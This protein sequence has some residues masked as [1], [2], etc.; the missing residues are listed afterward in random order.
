M[1]GILPLG[2][3]LGTTEPATP[4]AHDG[5]APAALTGDN[6]T[7]V[8][9]GSHSSSSADENS[10]PEENAKPE[11]NSKPFNKAL[12]IPIHNELN[13][14]ASSSMDNVAELGGAE[15]HHV[16]VAR[17]K[18]EFAALERKFSNMSQASARLKRTQTGQSAISRRFSRTTDVESTANGAAGNEKADNDD[19]VEF[20]LLETMRA[21][22]ERSDRAGIKHKEVGVVWEDLEVSPVTTPGYRSADLARL[23]VQEVSRSISA[24][25]S[26]RS[27]SRSSLP[28]FSSSAFSASSPLLPSLVPFFNLNL[29][30]SALE[31]C[32]SSSVGPTRVA[33]PS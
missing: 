13:Q 19:K 11:E 10:K 23:S 30:F 27:L 9:T 8:A 1:S 4:R 3:P 25:S 33:P 32:V 22:R 28:S 6:E 7:V 18:A 26:M 12:A 2:P 21:S 20:N 29:V 5:P 16:S 24:H 17:G 31:K 15:H 14:S